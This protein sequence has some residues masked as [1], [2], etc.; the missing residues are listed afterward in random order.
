M[1]K[2]LCLAGFV[3]SLATPFTAQDIDSNPLVQRRSFTTIADQISDPSE[4]SAFLDLFRPAS[5]TEML[6]RAEA[7]L[8]RFPQSSFLS[9]AYEVAARASFDLQ[10]YESG[11][12]YARQSLALLPENPLLLVAVADVEGQRRLNDDAIAHAV[13]ALQGLQSFAGP[14]SVREQEWPDVKRT[15]EASANFSKGRALLQQALELPAS[16]KRAQVLRTSESALASARHLNPTDVEITYTLG[17]AQL[18]SGKASEAATDFAAIYRGGSEAAPKALENLRAIHRLLYP[19]SDLPFETFVQ[20]AQDRLSSALQESPEGLAEPTDRAPAIHHESAYFGSA[21]CRGCHADIYRQWSESGMS[22]M[23]LPYAPENVL[24]DFKT[25]NEFYLGDEADYRGGKFRIARG[26]QR[27]LFARMVIRGDHHYFEMRQSDGQWHSYRVDYTIG[28]KFEQAYATTLPNGEIHVFPIQYNLLQK[29]WINFWKVIDG[30]ESE[31]AN[32]RTWEKLD[33]STSYQAICAVC[34]TSQLRNVKG[35]GFD[36]NHLEFKEPGINCEMCHGPSAE[37]VVEATSGEFY[38]RPAHS[39]PI[40][41]DGIDNRSFVAICA[42]CHMQSAIRKPGPTGELNY[43]GSGD[44]FGHLL[45]E[46]FG[47]FSRKGFY[48]DGRFRQTTFMVEA[49]ERSQCFKKAAVSCGTCHDPHSHGSAG[50]PTSLK[51]RDQPDR[52]CTGC[53]TQFQDRVRAAQH[54]HHAPE[55]EGSWCVSCHMPRI[56]DALLFRARYHQIDDIPN[57]A[58]TKRFGEEESP[59]ACLL[60]HSKNDADWVQQQ[61]S[62]WK[63]VTVS[64][65]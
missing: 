65:E 20:Q 8:S 14:S 42:Q 51:L 58:M 41:F 32:P 1:W 56:M 26:R 18:T 6:A 48:K 46:P 37:H 61:L 64:Q 15:L 27:T 36:I 5:P 53:H 59:N 33:G 22:K 43:S 39:P 29:Q 19:R 47:E 31:R 63:S 2:S 24:G 11:L 16:D 13:E 54:S 21:S 34:H 57:A 12:D 7:F 17:L 45:R 23:L 40:N 60:C 50:N 25:N 44:F 38:P 55:S 3:L 30:P 49:L 35:G 62:R 4:R 28:S 52:M 10:K 9:Q